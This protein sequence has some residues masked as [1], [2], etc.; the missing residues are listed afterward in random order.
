MAKIVFHPTMP[1]RQFEPVP[2]L[3]V[4]LTATVWASALYIEPYR[5][6]TKRRHMRMIREPLLAYFFFVFFFGYIDLAPAI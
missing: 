1:V 6:W 4:T 2:G 5:F 3:D